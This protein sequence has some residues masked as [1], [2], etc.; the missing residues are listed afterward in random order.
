MTIKMQNGED[1]YPKIVMHSIPDGEFAGFAPV[2]QNNIDGVLINNT[3]ALRYNGKIWEIVPYNYKPDTKLPA[4][5]LDYE[6]NIFKTL[7]TI[8]VVAETQKIPETI[9]EAMFPGACVNILIPESAFKEFFAAYKEE[10]EGALYMQYMVTTDD[11]DAFCE[12]AKEL[13]APFITAEGDRLIIQNITQLARLNHNITMIVML[14]GYGFIAML[15]LIAVTSVI[16][17]ISTGMALRTQEF[18]MLYSAGMTSNGM[19]KMLNLE[20]LMY[21]MKSIFIGL[22]VGLALSYLIYMGLLRSLCKSLVF[23]NTFPESFSALKF[24]AFQCLTK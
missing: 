12:T 21:G 9:P 10:M 6:N 15:S 3:G 5:F 8:T 1:Y 13:L 4:G 7:E 22:L 20:S 23:N 16:A 11:P 19:N 17:T 14:F 18:A 24:Q 2:N